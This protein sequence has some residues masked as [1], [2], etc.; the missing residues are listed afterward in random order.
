[1][2]AT[3][4]GTTNETD[5]G[6]SLRPRPRYIRDYRLVDYRKR[7]MSIQEAIVVIVLILIG[8]PC[9]T[10][11][12]LAVNTDILESFVAKIGKK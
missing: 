6:I 3:N 1:M 2:D 8:L 9:F 4:R 12:V 7:Y 5:K 10:L 11:I